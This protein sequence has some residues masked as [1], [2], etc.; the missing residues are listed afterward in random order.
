MIAFGTFVD[1]GNHESS[2]RPVGS[3]QTRLVSGLVEGVEVE[4]AEMVF[5]AVE[6][7]GGGSPRS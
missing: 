6:V 1:A 5:R 4:F 3:E 7:S 2:A